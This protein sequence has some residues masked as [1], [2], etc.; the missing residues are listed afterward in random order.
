[1]RIW[2][3]IGSVRDVDGC[4][5]VNAGWE[6]RGKRLEARLSNRDYEGVF[7]WSG[8]LLEESMCFA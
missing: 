8:E 7:M 1:M 3:N 2:R 4:Y 5:G 6:M